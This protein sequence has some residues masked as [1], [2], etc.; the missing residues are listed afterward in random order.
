MNIVKIYAWLIVLLVVSMGLAGC[1][2]GGGD[3]TT[4]SAGVFVKVD[5]QN[6]VLNPGSNQT[7]TATVTGATN[8]AVT[9]KAQKGSITAA[10]VYTAPE[11]AGTDTVTTFDFSAPGRTQRD[12][13]V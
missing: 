9:W 6:I 3:N 13:L 8:T 4:S 5:Q 7:F 2:G 1:G 12:A 10:G 11:T